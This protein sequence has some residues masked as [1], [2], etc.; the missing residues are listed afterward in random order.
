MATL[1]NDWLKLSSPEPGDILEIKTKNEILTA[2]DIWQEKSTGL[3]KIECADRSIHTLTIHEIDSITHIVSS[4]PIF[5]SK[6][7]VEHED[8]PHTFLITGDADIFIERPDSGYHFNPAPPGTVLVNGVVLDSQIP[9]GYSKRSSL[10]AGR[11]PVWLK[12]KK[13]T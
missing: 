3:I 5:F 10:A 4:N 7:A 6:P 8:L 12:A 9:Y 11:S 2:I 1:I 13:I